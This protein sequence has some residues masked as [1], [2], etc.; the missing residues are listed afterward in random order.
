MLKPMTETVHGCPVAIYA[1]GGSVVLGAC[2]AVAGGC[3]SVASRGL[4]AEGVRLFAQTRYDEAIQQFQQ[5]VYENPTDADGYYNLAA[6]Y[7]RLGKVNQRSAD[8]K[9][10]EHYYHMCLDQAPDH[11]ECYRG[12]AVLLIE[13]GKAD[14]AFQLVQGWADRN[15]ASPEPKIELARLHEEFGDKTAAQG[16]LVNALTIEPDNSRALAALGRLREGAGD[17]AQAL[18]DYRRSLQGDKF[19]E[20]VQQRVA[21]LQSRLTPAMSTSQPVT[22]P[23]GGTRVVTGTNNLLR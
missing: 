16:L 7:H 17:Q 4:N 3:G 8:L 23:P 15:P 12:L 2:L 6:T 22:T 10:A 13:Q 11:R 20:G 21:A 19:Q 9:Q 14:E 1:I 5:A 18:A